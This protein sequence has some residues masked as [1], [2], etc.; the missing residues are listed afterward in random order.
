MRE[1]Q[2]REACSRVSRFSTLAPSTVAAAG[3]EPL[4]VVST[5][6]RFP[7]DR[8]GATR[9]LLPREGRHEEMSV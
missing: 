7:T 6:R 4:P 2:V 3:D 8:K 1:P 5:Y 9:Y